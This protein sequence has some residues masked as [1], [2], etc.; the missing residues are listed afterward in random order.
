LLR[1][2]APLPPEPLR[3]SFR[4]KTP[5]HESD[6]RQG[7]QDVQDVLDRG[8]TDFD[9]ACHNKTPFKI[10]IIIRNHKTIG[11][12]MLSTTKNKNSQN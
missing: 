11:V 2:A 8:D 10:S 12:S 1:F 3:I 9:F 4:D 7:D 6:D 5:E